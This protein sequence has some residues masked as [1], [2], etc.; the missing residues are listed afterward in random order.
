MI[1]S[2]FP[3]NAWWVEKPECE[4]AVDH[5]YEPKKVS[6]VGHIGGQY[7]EDYVQSPP[8]NCFMVDVDGKAFMARDADL[9]QSEADALQAA[10][11]MLNRATEI[12]AE[13]IEKFH[14]RKELLR[15]MAEK[16]RR[17][18]DRELS[19]GALGAGCYTGDAA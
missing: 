13:K 8:S 15:S 10:I 1:K 12:A 14:G 2:P 16:T 9:Y 7:L 4:D 18:L 11:G 3:F 17:E 6:V 5:G 19:K